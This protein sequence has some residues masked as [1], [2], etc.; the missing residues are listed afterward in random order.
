MVKYKTK[1]FIYTKKHKKWVGD[2][3][4]V[5]RLCDATRLKSHARVSKQHWCSGWSH[6]AQ[7]WS[8]MVL[9]IHGEVAQ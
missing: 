2:F 1:R 6:T 5:V 4:T 7:F 3:W 9:S 8:D